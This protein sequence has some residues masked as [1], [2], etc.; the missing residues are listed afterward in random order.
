MVKNWLL[1]ASVVTFLASPASAQQQTLHAGEYAQAD[2]QY[3]STVYASQCTNCHGPNGDQVSGVDLRSGK[4]RNVFSDF[5]LQRIITVGIPGTSMPGRQLDTAQMTGLIAYLRNMR[6]FNTSAV[7]LGD[8]AQG[9]A[10]FEGRGQCM[11]CHS[12]VGKGS[13][14]APDLSDIGASRA[15]SALQKSLVDPN[16]MM[17]PINRP[18]RIVT[19][20]GKTI[21]GR[22]LNEDTYTVQLIDDH[23][24]LL[25]LS[26]ADFRE[27]AILQSSPMSSY[28]DKL[29]EGDISDLV[30]Y[31]VSLK[32]K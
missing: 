14:I 25:S 17:M 10:I 16:S 1:S 22:R 24:H 8:P 23:E 29:N 7:K 9:K 2:I 4:F 3:G 21:N 30:A 20:D 5:D 15:P 26:K 28:K 27:Y 11:T 19:K 32:G 12:V 13:H 6:D 31:L 18:I